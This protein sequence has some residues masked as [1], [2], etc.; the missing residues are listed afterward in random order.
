[1]SRV[2]KAAEYLSVEEV[3]Y[4]MQHDSRLLYRQR[5]LIIY[6]AMVDP[7]PAEEIARH[8]GVGTVTVQHLISRYNRF[9]ISAVETK[10]KGGRRREYLTFE[11]EQQFLK[12]FFARAQTGEMATVAEI[13]HAFEDRLEHSVDESTIYR[14]LQ[15]H[16]WRK[17]VPRPRHPQAREEAQEVFKKNSPHRFKQQWKQEMR[18]ITD[19][20][21]SWRKMKDVLDG[22][23]DHTPVGLLLAYGLWHRHRWSV[24]LSMFLLLLLLLLENSAL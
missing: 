1:M 18:K 5:W 4:R 13:H 19:R 7:R 21:S 3:K 8:C 15:R 2:T 22:L 6:N 14:L 24:K 17:V 23:V 16:G 10:G 20:C 9:G 12:P 11:Q